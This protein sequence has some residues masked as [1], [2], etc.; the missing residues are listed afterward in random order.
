MTG[1]YLYGIVT[2]GTSLPQSLAGLDGQPVT[3]IE[4]A[5][6][7]GVVSQLATM[8][9]LGT[10]EDLL[11]HQRVVA[12]LTETGAAVLP[13]RLGTVLAGTEAVSA[14]L[15]A[16]EAAFTEALDRVR[17]RAEFRLKARYVTDTAVA[18]VLADHPDLA[19]FAARVRGLPDDAAYFDRINLGRAIAAALARRADAEARLL[20]DALVPHADA[21]AMHDR[22]G[23]DEVLD[24]AF[25][26]DLGR[27]QDFEAAVDRLATTVAGRLRLR[28]AG[29]LPPYDFTTR[30]K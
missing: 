4:S 10:P 15:A 1:Q 11:A 12:R 16:N 17:G 3:V 28:L 19:A 9:P 24:A 2:A 8:R 30:E 25:L 27:R 22:T 23:Q 21:V 26:V 6:C 13:L 5:R 7:A 14:L 18:E 29:P 20:L